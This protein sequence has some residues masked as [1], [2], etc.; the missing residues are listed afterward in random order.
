MS[1]QVENPDER[2]MQYMQ[3]AARRI[4]RSRWG[5][6]VAPLALPESPPF[7]LFLLYYIM[8][9]HHNIAS[10]Y[11]VPCYDIMIGLC[12]ITYKTII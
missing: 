2:V 3:H 7:P 1:L 11:I 10:Q 9:L 5:G 4:V 6:P 8:S 12:D